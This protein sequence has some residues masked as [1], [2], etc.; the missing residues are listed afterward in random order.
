MF[1]K[2]IDYPGAVE[3]RRIS[4]KVFLM[5]VRDT[6]GAEKYLSLVN[7]FK[8]YES[9]FISLSQLKKSSCSILE[10]HDDL[11]RKFLEFMPTRFRNY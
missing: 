1:S 10:G 2:I 7:Q 4:A 8:G 9:R 5:E 3:T 11:I 6:L